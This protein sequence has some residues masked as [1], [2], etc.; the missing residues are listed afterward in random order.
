MSNPEM[1]H[2]NKNDLLARLNAHPVIMDRIE[3]LL[4]LV[5]NTDGNVILADDAEMRVVDE[6]RKMGSELLHDWAK[7]SSDKIHAIAA[8][9]SNLKKRDEKHP[10]AY[11]IWRN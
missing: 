4:N 5:E 11:H 10:L 1:N 3:S 2:Q 6:L 8:T 9:D 7:S